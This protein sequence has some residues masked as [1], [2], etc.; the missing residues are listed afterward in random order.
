MASNFPAEAKM[1]PWQKELAEI[2]MRESPHETL[3]NRWP[4]DYQDECPKAYG[5][6][7]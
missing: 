6:Q 3:C 1:P 7:T 4:G 2:S 5:K